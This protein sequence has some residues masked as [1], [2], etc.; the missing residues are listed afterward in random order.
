MATVSEISLSK[1]SYSVTVYVESVSDNLKNQL[2]VL[3]TPTVSQLQSNGPSGTKVA[4][5]LRI[6]RSFLI[7]GYILSNS[8][9]SNLVNIMNGAG[10]TGSV[11]T[12][13]Y[14]SG[15]DKTSFEGYIESCVI[16]QESSDEP[17]DEPD[18]YAKFA[19]TITFIEGTKMGGT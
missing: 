11:I 2:L 19:V 3:A 13:N 16:T 12:L 15:G 9:K 17:S 1:G 18:D 7:K 14:D 5:F 6:T 8:D 4:D 10:I